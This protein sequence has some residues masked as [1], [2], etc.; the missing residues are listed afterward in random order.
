MRKTGLEPVWNAPHAPQT[1]ASASSATSAYRT[2]RLV[3]TGVLPTVCIIAQPP[4]VV[5]PLPAIFLRSRREAAKKAAARSPENQG[6]AYGGYPTVTVRLSQSDRCVFRS[7]ET[8]DPRHSNFSC[9]LFI[10]FTIGFLFRSIRE[11]NSVMPC[12]MLFLISVERVPKR[13]NA[14]PRSIPSP[15]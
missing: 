15:S 6:S 10:C 3:K 4:P 9:N 7:P 12:G 1:C 11:A 8:E 2:D 14:S 13:S 5:N